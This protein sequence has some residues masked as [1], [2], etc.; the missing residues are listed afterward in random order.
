[1]SKAVSILL[2]LG[3]SAVPRFP[4]PVET[5]NLRLINRIGGINMTSDLDFFTAFYPADLLAFD[6]FA[7]SYR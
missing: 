3:L 1:M 5:S 2:V 4:R 7:A 6:P